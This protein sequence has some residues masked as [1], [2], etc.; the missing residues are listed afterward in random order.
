M[1][2]TKENAQLY[3][4]LGGGRPKGELQRYTSALKI[5][6]AE[7]IEKHKA[8]LIKAMIN[9]AEQGNVMAFVA[10]MD[11]AHGKPA[12]QFDGKDSDGNPIVFLPFQLLDKY[13]V[14]MQNDNKPLQLDAK[15]VQYKEAEN[16]KL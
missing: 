1:P 11:R 12:Q 10:L 8:P 16:K 9:E 13:G 6:I 5:Y 3:S 14:N 4:K 15:D 7:Q 2:F